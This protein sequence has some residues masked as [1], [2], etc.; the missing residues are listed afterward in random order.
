MSVNIL[1][2]Q[3][4]F[5]KRGLPCLMLR[6]CLWTVYQKM[7]VPVGT[8]DADYS[9]NNSEAESL[10]KYFKGAVLVRSTSGF[11]DV[12]DKWYCVLNDKFVSIDEMNH[13]KRRKIKRGLNECFVQKID[14]RQM[15]NEGWHVYSQAFRRYK[16]TRLEMNETQFLKD[17]VHQ[18][19]EDIIDYWGVFEKKSGRLVGYSQIF[20]YGK[21]EANCGDSRFHP[22]F[23]RLYS[24]YALF[25]ERSKYYLNEGS[26]VFVNNGFRSILHETTV[27]DLLVRQFNYRHQPVGI[28][29]YY[30][31]W[32][33]AG[34]A[35][36][37]PLHSLV[38][39]YSPSVAALYKLDELSGA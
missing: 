21:T 1:R 37:H 33:K 7:V 4:L 27:Q 12:P 39:K 25:Y 34:M 26:F 5:N 24:S 18:G 2:Y 10:L 15:K 8:V 29:L 32:F 6:N 36:I 14:T 38:G 9:L 13:E 16:N 20:L 11:V 30:R 31:P 17:I 35:L 3:A 19:F 23:L 22:D 28:K